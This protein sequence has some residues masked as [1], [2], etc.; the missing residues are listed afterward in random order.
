MDLEI[1]RLTKMVEALTVAVCASSTGSVVLLYLIPTIAI[2]FIV[3][4][5]ISKIGFLGFF[6]SIILMISSWFIG[7]CA[8]IFGLILALFSF[9]LIIYFAV[10]VP[11]GFKNDTFK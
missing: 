4:G 9:V 8:N 10:I 11:L 3:M 5:L 1:E 7:S 2:F 6:G